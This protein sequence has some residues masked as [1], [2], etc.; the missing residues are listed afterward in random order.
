[1]IKTSFYSARFAAL[2]AAGLFLFAGWSVKAEKVSL[3]DAA[4]AQAD[5]LR[6]GD[7]IQATLAIAKRPEYEKTGQKPKGVY[8]GVWN[9]RIGDYTTS[10]QD[11][12]GEVLKD[13]SDVFRNAIEKSNCFFE[14]K[15]VEEKISSQPG[16][17]ELLV[18]F[19]KTR[20]RYILTGE[21]EHF[22]GTQHQHSHLAVV[23]ALVVN[24]ASVADNVGMAEGVTEAV[25]A[26]YDTQTGYEIFRE[27]IDGAALTQVKGTYP[28]AAKD[29]L[30]KAAESLAKALYKHAQ[31][32]QG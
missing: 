6:C 29:S 31:S 13:V 12:G 21:L 14:V 19:S 7:A 10:E 5:V 25:F 22:Y 30:V 4:V 23:P 26:L 32:L 3:K 15:T 11:F 9:Q 18:A 27:K 28:Q 2:A 1:M 24:A 17:E 16:P 8:L 20:A